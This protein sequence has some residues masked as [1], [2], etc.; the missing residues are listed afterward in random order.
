MDNF[1]YDD[2]PLQTRDS[3][4]GVRSNPFIKASHLNPYN[5]DPSAIPIPIAALPNPEQLADAPLLPTVVNSTTLVAEH[6]TALGDNPAAP[7]VES[8]A[9]IVSSTAQVVKSTT[10]AF[11]DPFVFANWT[12]QKQTILSG[13]TPGGQP[14]SSLCK[15]RFPYPLTSIAFKKSLTDY[16]DAYNDNISLNENHK[17]YMINVLSDARAR[18]EKIST[19]KAKLQEYTTARDT[20]SDAKVELFFNG[21][22]NKII[23]WDYRFTADFRTSTEFATSTARVEEINKR[24][25]RQLLQELIHATTAELEY[26]TTGYKTATSCDAALNQAYQ[27]SKQLV[28]EQYTPTDAAEVFKNP[29]A[30][31]VL[32]LVANLCVFKLYA[33]LSSSESLETVIA[34]LLPKVIKVPSVKIKPEPSPASTAT[35]RLDNPPLRPQPLYV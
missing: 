7:V 17:A 10:P 24:Y 30:N 21:S 4:E 8:T 27:I 19:T 34:D 28:Y 2:L 1:V 12:S 23:N 33:K 15:D 9:P 20:E 11:D 35:L 32:N 13:S 29:A 3:I 16:Q 18:Q 31:E 6:R 14:L 22:F 25:K 26:L 5:L